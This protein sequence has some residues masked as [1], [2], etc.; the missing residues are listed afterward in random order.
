LGAGLQPV[1]VDILKDG[2]ALRSGLI[3]LRN[4][5]GEWTVDLPPELAGALQLWA[6]RFDSK[7]Y[8]VR[9]TRLAFVRSAKGISVMATADKPEY[10]PGDK[11]K[12]S[13]TLKDSAGKSVPGALS[14]AAVDEAV[15]A[16]TRQSP[17]QEATFFQLEQELLKPVYQVYPWSPDSRFD[18]NA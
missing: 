14:L 18:S 2:Q 5:K 16:V 1:F 4:G 13:F 9:K 3:E 12:I 7:G 15:F 17:G 6:Y 8:P 11:A 10:G